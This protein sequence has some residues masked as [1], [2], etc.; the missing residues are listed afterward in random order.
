MTGTLSFALVFQPGPGS[1]RKCLT[2]GR[3][4]S[5][6]LLDSRVDTGGGLRSV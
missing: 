5:P 3:D 4:L 1:L 6:F 2:G